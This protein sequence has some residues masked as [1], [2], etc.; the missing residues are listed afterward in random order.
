[1]G[2][3]KREIFVLGKLPIAVVPSGDREEGPG[4]GDNQAGCV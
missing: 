1:M 2:G 3:G 4:P